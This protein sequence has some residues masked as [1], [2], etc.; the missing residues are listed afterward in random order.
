MRLLSG[1]AGKSKYMRDVEIGNAHAV[2]PG[3]SLV[4]LRRLRIDHDTVT[5]N[6]KIAQ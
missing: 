1:A 4:P 6:P 5:I 3:R 2:T